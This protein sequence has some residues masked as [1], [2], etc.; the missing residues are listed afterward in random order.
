MQFSL[1]WNGTKD[2]KENS[3]FLHAN[4]LI[5]FTQDLRMTFPENFKNQD[6]ISSDI[7][8]SDF[9]KYDFFT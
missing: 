8:S 4:F 6:F 2:T 7:L 5:S 3:D 1:T 9:K